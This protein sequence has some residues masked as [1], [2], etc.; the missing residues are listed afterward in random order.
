MNDYANG[1]S[2]IFLMYISHNWITGTITVPTASSAHHNAS[3]SYEN[4]YNLF[5]KN[6][7]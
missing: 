2:Y 4:N 1:Y 6:L 7:V 3:W 5:L